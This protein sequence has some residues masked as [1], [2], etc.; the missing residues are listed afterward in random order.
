[1]KARHEAGENYAFFDTG[2]VACAID[3]GYHQNLEG[4]YAALSGM[5]VYGV[6]KIPYIRL[7]R[8][9]M[10]ET[11]C[12]DPHG[13]LARRFRLYVEY[14]LL[15]AL[16]ELADQLFKNGSLLEWPNAD[17]MKDMFLHIPDVAS[18][19]MLMFNFRSY[20]QS[21]C[22]PSFERA[23]RSVAPVDVCHHE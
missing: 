14:Q 6:Q 5:M 4:L 11:M 2:V 12:T 16:A 20:Y 3:R 8:T 23:C 17:E 22:A 13:A 19:E 1:M 9:C 18:R 10:V 7:F 21:W 15:P